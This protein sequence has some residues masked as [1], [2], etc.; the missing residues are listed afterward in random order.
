MIAFLVMVSE[1]TQ[2]GSPYIKDSLWLYLMQEHIDFSLVLLWSTTS[3]KL[4][5]LF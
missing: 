2:R 3:E 1:V 4:I 5:I